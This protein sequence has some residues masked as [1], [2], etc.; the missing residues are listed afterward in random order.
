M[1]CLVLPIRSKRMPRYYT[2]LQNIT[3]QE[4]ISQYQNVLNYYYV[5]IQY[6]AQHYVYVC[7]AIKLHLRS[8]YSLG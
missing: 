5:F 3:V 1:F 8:T 6:V 7:T 2:I 4:N